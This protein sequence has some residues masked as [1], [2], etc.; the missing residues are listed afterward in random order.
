V[1]SMLRVGSLLVIVLLT[2]PAVRDCCLPPAQIVP[3]HGTSP[4]ADQSCILN[5]QA[6]IPVTSS[7]G[8]SWITVFPLPITSVYTEDQYSLA[9]FAGGRTLPHVFIPDIN[10]RT[11][12]LLI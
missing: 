12:A 4:G 9:F 6:I 10:L 1:I 7:D 5:Q 2:V 3:C 11:G 8:A